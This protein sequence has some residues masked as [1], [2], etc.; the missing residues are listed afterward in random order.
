M[1]TFKLSNVNLN[2]KVDWFNLGN[3]YSKMEFQRSLI[4]RQLGLVCPESINS[5]IVISPR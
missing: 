1:K 3:V 4:L 2:F 5:K